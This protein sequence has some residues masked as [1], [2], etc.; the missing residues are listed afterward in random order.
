MID[1]LAPHL[2]SAGRSDADTARR[3]P[4][5]VRYFRIL[6]SNLLRL[7][8][9]STLENGNLAHIR[10]RL[11]RHQRTSRGQLAHDELVEVFGQHV[12]PKAEVERNA[13]VAAEYGAQL[14]ACPLAI[15][16]VRDMTQL[17][18]W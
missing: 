15:P 14:R 18:Q 8:V 9:L 6:S 12:V 17:E 16:F 3:N 4:G 7:R 5:R 10:V 2:P 1:R 13:T 11:V